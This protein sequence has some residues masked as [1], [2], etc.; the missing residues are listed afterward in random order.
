MQ[1]ENQIT[2]KEI[3]NSREDGKAPSNSQA[4]NNQFFIKNIQSKT[5]SQRYS[6]EIELINGEVISLNGFSSKDQLDNTLNFN[7][8]TIKNF[9]LVIIS[10]YFM[11]IGNVL[12]LITYL[13]IVLSPSYSMEETNRISFQ[14]ESYH[15]MYLLTILMTFIGQTLME[16]YFDY[17]RYKRSS[18]LNNNPATIL[19]RFTN[20]N[21]FLKQ[22]NKQESIS[23]YKQIKT[24]D[25]QVG[26]IVFVRKNEIFPADIIILDIYN[27]Y[28]SSNNSYS[29]GKTTQNKIYPIPITQ[30]PKFSKI[31]GNHFEYKK[32]LTGKIEY[33]SS[34]ERNNKFEGFINV[35]KD[36]VGTVVAK[37]N[38]GF[39]GSM[40][41]Y[42][43]W[44]IGIAI[45]TGKE[46]Y[47]Y[48]DTNQHWLQLKDKKPLSYFNLKKEKYFTLYFFLFIFCCLISVIRTHL[49]TCFGDLPKNNSLGEPSID[50][51]SFYIGLGYFCDYMLFLPS[52]YY[53]FCDI[54]ELILALVANTSFE[55]QSQELLKTDN[56][57]QSQIP[58]VN[59]IEK[60]SKI[61]IYLEKI[62][63]FF[64]DDIYFLKNSSKPIEDLSLITDC[65]IDKT[66]TLTKGRSFE[67][68]RITLQDTQYIISESFNDPI[69]IKKFVSIDY[70]ANE[71]SY[72][73]ISRKESMSL[74]KTNKQ[75][76][77]VITNEVTSEQ[78]D[79][80]GEEGVFL[81]HSIPQAILAK[82]KKQV[83]TKNNQEEKRVNSDFLEERDKE[84]EEDEQRDKII[85]ESQNEK[86]VQY[87]D[88]PIK[89]NGNDFMKS[90]QKLIKFQAGF[91]DQNFK[92]E[93]K[94]IE[95]SQDI[96]DIKMNSKLQSI[97]NSSQNVN[98]GY[99]TQKLKE[100][101]TLDM[102]KSL[103]TDQ[104]F[105][106]RKLT[107]A[108]NQFIFTEQ[109][110][111]R[112]YE[113]I[114]S[115]S[116]SYSNQ[117]E[118]ILAMIICHISKSTVNKKT[119][120][121]YTDHQ[122]I[123]DS[124]F[125]SFANRFE[126]KFRC[127]S[128]LLDGNIEYISTLGKKIYQH[129]FFIPSVYN[130]KGNRL[131]LLV[132]CEDL[133][134]IYVREE[135]NSLPTYIRN[136]KQMKEKYQGHIQ[137]MTENGQIGIIFSRKLITQSLAKQM[138]KK[139][140]DIKQII[141]YSQL[142]KLTE[143]IYREQL[144]E[145]DV[146]SMVSI[147]EKLNE[148]SLELIQNL[149]KSQINI[150]MLTGDD[151]IRAITTAY[152]SQIIE[153]TDKNEIIHF[154]SVADE[155]INYLIQSSLSKVK[156][157][158]ESD[159]QQ[160]FSKQ[161][162]FIRQI[163]GSQNGQKLQ[164]K[165]QMKANTT[166]QSKKFYMVVNGEAL[167][168]I[169]STQNYKDHFMFLT[170]F[171]ESFIGYSLSPQQKSDLV[172]IKKSFNSNKIY[173][174][175]IGDGLNDI[176]MMRQA[177][178]SIQYMDLKSQSIQYFHG[179]SEISVQKIGDINKLIFINSRQKSKNFENLLLFTF[180][181]Q[182]LIF[183]SVFFWNFMQCS[184]GDLIYNKNEILLI[185]TICFFIDFLIIYFQKDYYNNKEILQCMVEVQ[186]EHASNIRASSFSIEN[187]QRLQ[188][189]FQ[190]DD[191]LLYKQ[192]KQIVTSD[193]L[194]NFFL[195]I[196]PMAIMS[197]LIL[198]CLPYY[199]LGLVSNELGIIFERNEVI[200]ILIVMFVLKIQIG[201]YI[202][203]EHQKV[204]GLGQ[205]AYVIIFALAYYS[206]N[207]YDLDLYQFI[208]INLLLSY[209][210][211][212]LLSV[213]NSLVYKVF[214]PI[215]KMQI[216]RNFKKQDL[217]E[218]SSIQKEYA[219]ESYYEQDKSEMI[220]DTTE[221]ISQMSPDMQQGNT[222]NQK[223]I[224]DNNFLSPKQSI[225]SS[226]QQLKRK[227]LNIEIPK[228]YNN[229]Y[230]SSRRNSIE[231]N[232]N[233]NFIKAHKV[234]NS[235]SNS[236]SREQ[237]N[238]QFIFSDRRSDSVNE[239][240]INS[241]ND[242]LVN[243][244]SVNTNN[245]GHNLT[246]I[247]NQNQNDI[248]DQNSTE[249]N[250]KR[251][252]HQSVQGELEKNTINLQDINFSLL[253]RRKFTEERQKQFE[254]MSTRKDSLLRNANMNK[255]EI[256]K[257]HS[258]TK[259][260]NQN[261]SFDN[262]IKSVNK[263]IASPNNLNSPMVI[264]EINNSFQNEQK[265]HISQGLSNVK[266]LHRKSKILM[267]Q[268]K[269]NIKTN[270]RNAIRLALQNKFFF[271]G[272]EINEIVQMVFQGR[273]A[274]K[275]VME[276]NPK[277]YND[278]S[279][280]IKNIFFKF[281]KE[282]V[283]KQFQ[284]Q[285]AKEW[286]F[287][288]RISTLLFSI[289]CELALAQFMNSI[290]HY[291]FGFNTLSV[292]FGIQFLLWGFM[293]TPIYQ[294]SFFLINTLQLLVRV[295]SRVI[296]IFYDFD[297]NITILQG[298]FYSSIIQYSIVMNPP[299]Q[300]TAQLFLSITQCI[301][302]TFRYQDSITSDSLDSYLNIYIILQTYCFFISF[303]LFIFYQ[304]CTYQIAM[305]K[306]FEKINKLQNESKKMN[307]VL[308]I[309]LPK[310]I[311]ENIQEK[312]LSYQED[313]GEVAILFC[314][315]CD[316]DSVIEQ[317]KKNVIKLLDKLFRIYDES[318]SNY[319]LQ[320]IETVGKTYMAA[321]GLKGIPP[322]KKY[323][324]NN[325][326]IHP[327]TNSVLMAYDMYENAKKITYGNKSDKL[328]VKIG[329]H[330]GRV[331]AGVIG[332]HKP[333]FSLIGD[334]VNMASRVCSTG[335][336]DSVTIS[337]EARAQC[338]KQIEFLNK[339]QQYF[340]LKYKIL[341]VEKNVEAKGKGIIQT[342]QIVFQRD[343]KRHLSRFYNI[344]QERNITSSN[345]LEQ[346]NNCLAASTNLTNQQ[347][348]QEFEQQQQH[349]PQRLGNYSKV[350]SAFPSYQESQ[351]QL[352]AVS[353]LKKVKI[354]KNEIPKRLITDG[355]NNTEKQ[356]NSG[357]PQSVFNNAQDTY[358]RIMG[359]DLGVVPNIEYQFE[360]NND[361]I[362]IERIQQN[363][364][365]IENELSTIQHNHKQIVNQIS[366]V[367]LLAGKYNNEFWIFQME[368]IM[369]SNR[370][371]KQRGQILLIFEIVKLVMI[372]LMNQYL[373]TQ[374]STISLILHLV[375]IIMLIILTFGYQKIIK[376]G[377]NYVKLFVFTSF[378]LIIG[379]MVYEGYAFVKQEKNQFFTE[380]QTSAVIIVF[381]MFLSIKF[382]S[383]LEK[384]IYSIALI[385]MYLLFSFNNNIAKIEYCYTTIA[386]I[387][388]QLFNSFQQLE[389]NITSFQ[390][391]K[392]LDAKV[393]EQNKLLQYLLPS[394]IRDMFLQNQAK[395]INLIDNFDNVTIL[396]ADIAGFTKYSASVRPENVVFM[397]RELFT[398]FDQK[399]Q[400]NDVFKLYTIGDCY[401]V[402][403]LVNIENR[404]YAKEALNV[405]KMG[406][407][408]IDIIQQVRAVVNFD[409]LEM[410]I[411]IHTG[412]IIGG[413]VG[414]GVVR[415]DIYGP[416]V[417]IANKMESNGESGRVMIS[418][419]TY[420][421][422]NDGYQQEYEFEQARLIKIPA[423]NREIQGYLVKKIQREDSNYSFKYLQNGEDKNIDQ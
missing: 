293:F 193:V 392:Q 243:L 280:R 336:A 335:A 283:E 18:E 329:I 71:P 377:V 278:Y 121:L 416:D 337:A 154:N 374:G 209:S 323:L 381:S 326:R 343:T 182:T 294:D 73:Q 222:S 220:K 262:Q 423:Y 378:L 411:G 114:Q 141:D 379:A 413:V 366:F 2:A 9:I 142:H 147:K 317:E 135:I 27:S 250:N 249:I 100:Y 402:M 360:I 54:T 254:E 14:Q 212:L 302:Y 26:D 202:F 107:S 77:T 225:Y 331:M 260:E 149:K 164:E 166:A 261:E 48:Q 33:V 387:L 320:K 195:N 291:S 75:I 397:L 265:S 394:H 165:Q 110:D 383:I 199:S 240:Q 176:Q 274:D 303:T 133:Y 214:F 184:F 395:T 160:I 58:P 200:Y 341:L 123:Y 218:T 346:T 236:P 86:G 126:C 56:Q 92:I 170:F 306:N 102:S 32:I 70:T 391:R 95:E 19:E 69:K 270:Q 105:F 146:V 46:C 345:T 120:S 157:S 82:Q 21:Y 12:S 217:S 3:T 208:S 330:Y 259:L 37:E 252:S 398:K 213:I 185:N 275:I 362:D 282:S 388:T 408:M 8:M 318:C 340:N 177:D 407:C 418:E 211:I 253:Q 167:N 31:K 290:N 131:Q 401:V 301:V 74:K 405:I 239:F 267:Q 36:P 422:V 171:C 140:Q 17:L 134:Y 296:L 128:H 384:I 152:N 61:T 45:Y 246:N 188:N 156:L 186:K 285:V 412:S 206:A 62:R 419:A 93:S 20:F 194:K 127:V 66:G 365:E 99:Q 255:L 227:R 229:G 97:I 361:S 122:S 248:I 81:R 148:G 138:I 40:L 234:E 4:K 129:K 38:I 272:Y 333:Q 279:Y 29:C 315:I 338:F 118:A 216:Q 113:E 264:Q 91:D 380:T 169:L 101:K 327:V 300:L 144:Y 90:N 159:G 112:F 80:A 403:G 124:L 308:S 292:C 55:I 237:I 348:K 406:F 263:H 117:K 386:I 205:L 151:Y 187:N 139:Y 207:Y 349:Q 67:I 44:V 295:L 389:L 231:N 87:F 297:Y 96:G 375:S 59:I 230:L 269:I 89:V 344:E 57:S 210:L 288:S 180:Y 299:I 11:R 204:I 42:S 85:I 15:L 181:R 145:M 238:G 51:Q 64:Q 258:G 276:M 289:I 372:N 76:I 322:V 25:V 196:L 305:R 247:Q 153:K 52:I 104:F 84:E 28:C 172:M 421:L 215:I 310:F 284:K 5:Q 109:N 197:G 1:Q 324:I 420:N 382:Y 298:L 6:R 311:R 309:L 132:Q 390:N 94:S 136:I 53:F 271:K 332:G 119:T 219:L 313:Q 137:N 88:S 351:F 355:T 312:G 65:F 221:Q 10:N 347:A 373:G 367:D 183:S 325:E 410:R 192:N 376:L 277:N 281:D 22:S 155:E 24:K 350:N 244:K 63:K 370:S 143:Q 189:A 256:K 41:E 130:E 47:Y 363:F 415:Y 223:P 49:N 399:C 257:T 39:R 307:D 334:T 266:N 393:S 354:N 409:E 168:K 273:D 179:L 111:S 353:P 30:I 371:M 400:E 163:T 43:D 68:D 125:I 224:E 201:I 98:H 175:A 316:F 242:F 78:N 16:G 198:F 50:Q 359:T 203:F 319:G 339:N 241:G 232:S 103:E 178:Y 191:T 23:I 356:E 228:L 116:S 158:L 245:N 106:K 286:I 358:L 404:D 251:F 190:I 321:G 414:T 72:K 268:N 304:N 287:F 352:E 369:N 150:W 7:L 161:K 13:I 60:D 233:F 368:K 342:F 162:E 396:Y 173:T 115:N 83:E 174:L 328:N 235:S 34:A 357:R 79:I 108:T 226:P 314:D 35:S 364:N 417:V 385:L